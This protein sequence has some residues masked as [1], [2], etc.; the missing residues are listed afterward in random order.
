MKTRKNRGVS[1]LARIYADIMRNYKES[2]SRIG[3]L[4]S[5]TKII[6][7][8]QDIPKPP[9][10]SFDYFPKPIFDYVFNKHPA[11][12]NV[13]TYKFQL[14]A[15]AFNIRREF[16][17]HFIVGSAA[18]ADTSR[19]AH[20]VYSWLSVLHSKLS[21]K[22]S[23]RLDI[24]IYMTN[25]KK[26]LGRGGDVLDAINVNTGLTTSCPTDSG[27]IIIYRREE[28]FKVFIHESFHSFGLDLSTMNCEPS[29]EKIR[30]L[31]G[32]KHTEVNIYE[33][34]VEFWATII[35]TMFVMAAHNTAFSQF[36]RMIGVEIAHSTRQVAK[37]LK[38]MGLTYADLLRGDGSAAAKYMEKTNVFSYYILKTI[39][40]C[41]YAEFI[42][43]C[44]E[45]TCAEA[46]NELYLFIERHYRRVHFGDG[47]DGGRGLR[48][49]ALTI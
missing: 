48:M 10:L 44:G 46:P 1:T 25:F 23:N 31:F 43:L 7:T 21:S 35:H 28:W 14:S 16:I 17:V 26:E 41:H 30:R 36:K 9:H 29:N 3:N 33:A 4:S 37:I 45:W 2:R 39:L 32:I 24:Y 49:T 12:K 11:L 40:L 34:H 42:K 15:N 8:L 13:I 47:D 38:Y 19:Y 22:C 5:T 18:A 20:L 27:F 6:H